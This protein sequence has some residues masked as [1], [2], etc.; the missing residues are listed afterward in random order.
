M[1]G[2]TDETIFLKDYAPT[3]YVIEIV[4]LDVA[5]AP[6][7]SRVRA[8]LTISPRDGTSPGFNRGLPLDTDLRP[9]PFLGALTARGIGSF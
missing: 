1:R 5:I 6:E 2:E 3:P 7:T 9:K 4:E 8:L